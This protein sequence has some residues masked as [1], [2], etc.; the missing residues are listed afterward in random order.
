MPSE[1]G[2]YDGAA[3]ETVA[4]PNVGATV[5]DGSLTMD[6]SSRDFAFERLPFSKPLSPG[7]TCLAYPSSIRV[8]ARYRIAM[9]SSARANNPN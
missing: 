6:V 8:R 2:V 4:L 5:E 9:S 3:D 1:L 7:P